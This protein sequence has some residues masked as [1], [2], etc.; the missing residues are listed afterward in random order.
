MVEEVKGF[1]IRV[2]KYIRKDKADNEALENNN[3]LGTNTLILL[4]TIKGI[5]AIV[6]R[7]TR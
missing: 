1:F 2:S 6:K 3:D 7:E 4:D 5:T